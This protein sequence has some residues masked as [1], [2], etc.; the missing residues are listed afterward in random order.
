MREVRGASAT[1]AS[2]WWASVAERSAQSLRREATSVSS[3]CALTCETRTSG[4][5]TTALRSRLKDSAC[6]RQCHRSERSGGAERAWATAVVAA[7]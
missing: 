6:R 7:K 4:A 5:A 3:V 1:A 2:D